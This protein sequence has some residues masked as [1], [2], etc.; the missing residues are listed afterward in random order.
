VEREEAHPIWHLWL[1]RGSFPVDKD[2]TLASRQLRQVLKK[3]G[4]KV[5]P[6]EFWA[7]RQDGDRLRR[8]FLLGLG[9]REASLGSDALA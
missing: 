7:L 3:P 2:N 5:K 9:V 6:D 4:L 8:V 1:K